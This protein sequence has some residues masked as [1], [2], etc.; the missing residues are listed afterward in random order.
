MDTCEV[1]IIQVD[2]ERKYN[3]GAAIVTI[4]AEVVH[5]RHE[6]SRVQSEGVVSAIPSAACRPVNSVNLV[7]TGCGRNAC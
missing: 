6:R 1:L 4:K 5:A 3:V 2:R 7:R